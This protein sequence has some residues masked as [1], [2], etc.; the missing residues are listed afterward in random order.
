MSADTWTVAQAKAR[1]SELVEQA[2][3]KGPQIVTRHGRMPW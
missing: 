3:H 2:E 1:F